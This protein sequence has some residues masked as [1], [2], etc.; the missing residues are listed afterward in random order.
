MPQDREFAVH[1]NKGNH[2]D[3]KFKKKGGVDVDPSDELTWA[4]FQKGLADG[5][6]RPTITLNLHIGNFNTLTGDAVSEPDD[7][8]DPLVIKCVVV[9]VGGTVYKFCQ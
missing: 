1:L 6:I 3:R 4:Q 7:P 9:N 2:G 5:T 8:L